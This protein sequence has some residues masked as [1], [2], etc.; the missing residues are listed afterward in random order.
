[1]GVPYFALLSILLGL[2]SS[3]VVA[4]LSWRQMVAAPNAWVIIGALVISIGVF[5]IAN[6]GSLSRIS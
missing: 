6:S 2:L 5:A 1:M 4:L 3:A